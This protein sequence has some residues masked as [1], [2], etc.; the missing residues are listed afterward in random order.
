MPGNA[1][2]GRV[3]V[4]ET[5][6]GIPDLLVVLFDVDLDSEREDLPKERY[7][8]EGHEGDAAPNVTEPLGD[9]IGS[10]V[11]DGE[12]SFQFSFKDEEFRI[13]D[14]L[15]VRPDLYVVVTAPEEVG[16]VPQVLYRSAQARQNAGRREEFVISLSVSSLS[17]AGIPIPDEPQGER[18]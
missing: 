7:E 14:D 5:G 18:D 11:T 16:V 3:V 12:G 10:R 15:E 4:K 13:R 2:R 9:R 6:A 1:I 17:G 8:D